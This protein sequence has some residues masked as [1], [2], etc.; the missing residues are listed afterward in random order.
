[1]RPLLLLEVNRA[2]A[3]RLDEY[4]E[5]LLEIEGETGTAAA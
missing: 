3:H 4:E 2:L 5:H 1:M